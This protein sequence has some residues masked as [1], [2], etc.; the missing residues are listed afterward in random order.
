MAQLSAL[1]RCEAGRHRLEM[2]KET[3]NSDT[4]PRCYQSPISIHPNQQS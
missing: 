1:C 2:G 3:I 4:Y